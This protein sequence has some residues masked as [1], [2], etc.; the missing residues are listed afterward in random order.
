M[1]K[2]LLYSTICILF[3]SCKSFWRAVKQIDYIL[4]EDRMDKKTEI[5]YHYGTKFPFVLN[6]GSIFIPCKMNDTTYFLFYDTGMGNAI[7]EIIPA[8]AKFPKE[9]KKKIK[10]SIGTPTT[11]YVAIKK[12]LKHY[13]IKS[14]FFD[15]KKIVGEVKS[16]SSDTFML[17]CVSENANSNKIFLGLYAFPKRENCMF[18]NFSDTTVTP[19]NADDIYDTTGFILVKSKFSRKIEVC[20][21]VDSIEYDFF[22]DTGFDGFLSL[23]QYKEYRKCSKVKGKTACT[24]H[25]DLQYEKHKKDSDISISGFI[26][27]DISGIVI[28]TLIIQQTNTITMSDLDSIGGSIYYQKSRMPV[29]GMQFIS[30]FDWIID[31]HNKKIYAKKIKDIEDIESYFNHYRVNVFDTT[32]QISLLPV[33]KTEYQLFSVIDSVNG[34]KVNADNICQMKTLLNK[35][36]GFKDNEI[37]VLPP[38]REH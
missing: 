15:F 20:L 19:L 4:K 24:I 12:G 32:L 9:C 5:T 16:V 25:K 26:S 6:G 35:K 37:V 31:R 8:N 17:K 7:N 18:L 1:K 29:M 34:E 2:V 30:H 38:H 27:I 10:S 36:N 14:D 22:F 3:C 33:G 11:R 28:D 13:D 21:T 23:P